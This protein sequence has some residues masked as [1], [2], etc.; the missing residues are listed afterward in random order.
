MSQIA[1]MDEFVKQGRSI[2]DSS[3]EMIA[4]AVESEVGNAVVNSFL[5][6]FANKDHGLIEIGFDLELYAKESVGKGNE[7][8]GAGANKPANNNATTNSTTTNTNNT[9]N[10]TSNPSNSTSNANNT[11]NTNSNNS[12]NNN[13]NQNSTFSPPVPSDPN[14]VYL[15]SLLAIF[16]YTSVE[17][18]TDLPDNSFTASPLA[19]SIVDF[20][21]DNHPT[22]AKIYQQSNQA[23][24]EYLIDAS[25]KI[26]TVRKILSMLKEQASVMQ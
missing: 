10:S 20:L 11:N 16:N 23:T 22:L 7:T 13:P 8:N 26:L 2:F 4:Y 24:S 9:S 14:V 19:P 6:Y 21:V 3:E 18:Y 5:I 12:S 1:G 25:Y 17:N 15:R